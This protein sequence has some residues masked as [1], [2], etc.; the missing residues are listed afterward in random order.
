MSEIAKLRVLASRL[1]DLAHKLFTRTDTDFGDEAHEISNEITLTIIP[2]LAAPPVAPQ[3][4]GL[5][6]VLKARLEEAV[7]WEHLA[8]A[9]NDADGPD[10]EC[11]YCKRIAGIKAALAASEKAGKP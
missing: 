2:A 11:E 8:P 10:P 6:E 9:C 5:R 1:D 3:V 7:W 4:T